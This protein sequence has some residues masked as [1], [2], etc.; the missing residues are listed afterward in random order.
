MIDPKVAVCA[1]FLVVSSISPLLATTPAPKH[2]GQ[3]I[4][5]RSNPATPV[6]PEASP[7]ITP[8][9]QET[10]N[11]NE[12]APIDPLARR[13]SR[14]IAADLFRTN[15]TAAVNAAEIYE[16]LDREDARERRLE[17]IERHD[18]DLTRVYVGN[19]ATTKHA[20]NREEKLREIQRRVEASQD[21]RTNGRNRELD[22]KLDGMSVL[23]A[24]FAPAITGLVQV[25][26][27]MYPGIVRDFYYK[28]QSHL[29]SDSERTIDRLA[30]G[31]EQNA[32]QTPKGRVFAKTLDGLGYE[33]NKPL[34]KHPAV[35]SAD[36]WVTTQK[37]KSDTDQILKTQAL[38]KKEIRQIGT[39]VKA[40]ARQAERDRADGTARQTPKF[41]GRLRD[42][43]GSMAVLGA[44]YE[45]DGQDKVARQIYTWSSVTG[46][47]ADLLEHAK[48]LSTQ[49]LVNGWVGLAVHILLSSQSSA[50]TSLA[51]E[52][53]KELA[54]LTQQV[55]ELGVRLQARLNQ[56]DQHLGGLLAVVL[57]DQVAIKAD[58]RF[59]SEQVV[60][61]DQ[62]LRTLHE[63]LSR[64]NF[65]L[66]AERF[67]AEDSNCLGRDGENHVLPPIPDFFRCRDHYLHRA[68]IFSRD[69]VAPT[70]TPRTFSLDELARRVP[71]A[72]RYREFSRVNKFPLLANGDTLADPQRWL[73]GTDSLFKF[74]LAHPKHPNDFEIVASSGGVESPALDVTMN[75]GRQIR[76]FEDWAAI[77]GKGIDSPAV[78]R[79][80]ATVDQIFDRLRGVID[81]VDQ[82]LNHSGLVMD[83]R[84]TPEIPPSNDTIYA[85]QNKALTAVHKDFKIEAPNLGPV[86]QD[87]LNKL[88]T[89]QLATN[90]N[91]ADVIAP[92]VRRLE[93]LHPQEF[94]I[95]PILRAFKIN[96]YKADDANVS[97][98][99]DVTY[100]IYVRDIK[101]DSLLHVQTL[102]AKDIHLTFDFSE[103]ERWVW[104]RNPGGRGNFSAEDF[105]ASVWTELKDE[106][107]WRFVDR[108]DD[109]TRLALASITERLEV[110]YA[111]IRD[112]IEKLSD[113]ETR[114]REFE[115][116]KRDLAMMITIDRSA[117][118]QT[119]ARLLL[120]LAGD[121]EGLMS[122]EELVKSILANRAS[123]E[124]YGQHFEALRQ[125][126]RGVLLKLAAEAPMPGADSNPVEEQVRDLHRLREA[127]VK[128]Y[129]ALHPKTPA[130]Q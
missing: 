55:R 44:L 35:Q 59:T 71:F 109:D 115:Q 98:R 125:S 4:T 7:T 84:Q 129:L 67:A 116:L 58:V 39:A 32:A 85:F 100:E 13:Q 87:R 16:H 74:I 122:V 31:I 97:M 124:W 34:S 113:I 88:D 106:G 47:A 80:F 43:A 111:R 110:E 53:L 72:D 61:I 78:R 99:S 50:E 29:I 41:I 75:S 22:E 83:V 17:V 73:E 24:P 117:I 36:Q 119:S 9:P 81:F 40:L 102:E 103:H 82:R 14:V 66:R 128:D 118:D 38:Q 105:V 68:V 5:A 130:T 86:I 69:S 89:S 54:T 52:I 79:A 127:R 120:T 77:R 64:Q 21:G 60:T 10:V 6:A 65:D 70:E 121:R 45:Y 28:D 101:N 114:T 30:R 56:I 96:D 63:A 25:G 18:P 15:P 76:A 126:M 90:V 26:K 123:L 57:R 12:D 11:F 8:V 20:L 92:Q 19:F 95:V 37:I 46:R 94:E 2:P 108:P 93:Q 48:D 107:G 104:G 62:H 49:A 42:S 27:A 51:P 3:R 1:G 33:S 112:H 91:L 23:A